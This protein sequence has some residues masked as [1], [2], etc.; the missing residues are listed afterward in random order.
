MEKNNLIGS[1][2]LVTGTTVGAGMIALPVTTGTYGFAATLFMFI[3]VWLASLVIAFA[4]LEANL[5]HKEGANL[6]TMISPLWG[7]PER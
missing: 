2:F 5:Q 7:D 3:T 1:I 6:I 4:M